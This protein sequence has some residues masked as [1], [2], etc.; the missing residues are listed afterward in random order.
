MLSTSI[1]LLFFCNFV[2]IIVHLRFA[3]SMLGIVFGGRVVTSSL[4]REKVLL[5]C[6][7]SRRDVH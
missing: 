6:F 2:C 7:Y 4:G 5:L 3:F 1:L